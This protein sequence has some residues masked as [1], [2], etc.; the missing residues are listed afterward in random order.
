MFILRMCLSIITF[1]DFNFR[2]K[3][4]E[5]SFNKIKYNNSFQIIYFSFKVEVY[6][7]LVMVL[8]RYFNF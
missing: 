6:F 7:F 2:I 4:L 5:F 8:D 3:D 1:R